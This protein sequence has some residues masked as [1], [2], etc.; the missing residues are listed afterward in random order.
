[1]RGCFHDGTERI[2][3]ELV[4]PAYAGVFPWKT[5]ARTTHGR[6]PRVCGGVSFDPRWRC[7]VLR[8]SPR[9]RGCFPREERSAVRG[10]VFPAYAGVFRWLGFCTTAGISLPRVCG[11]V[12]VSGIVIANP[13]GSSPRV[14]G[15]NKLPLWRCGQKVGPSSQLEVPTGICK[16][17]SILRLRRICNLDL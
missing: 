5:P 16:K 14:A 17:K 9:M 2:E 10:R 4:F 11:G 15:Q 6:L 3:N 13:S 12:S 7:H 1:M 8:S